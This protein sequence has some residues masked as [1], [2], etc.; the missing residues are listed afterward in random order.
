MAAALGIWLAAVAGFSILAA[1][2]VLVMILLI[3]WASAV[4][5]SLFGAE[6]QLVANV[7]SQVFGSFEI[8]WNI[9]RLSLYL[10]SA[11]LIW[12]YC[13]RRFDVLAGRLPVLRVDPGRLPQA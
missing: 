10:L 4:Y 12:L 7:S 6:P 2:L 9:V 8:L 3:A 1:L 5:A 13:R 11:L